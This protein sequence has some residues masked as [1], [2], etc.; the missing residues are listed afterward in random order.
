MER[1]GKECVTFSAKSTR[2]EKFRDLNVRE[3]S[4]SSFISGT[5]K[6]L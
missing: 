2:D 6:N 3:T 1:S 5:K 4:S